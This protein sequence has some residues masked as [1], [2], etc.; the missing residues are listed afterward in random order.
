MRLRSVTYQFEYL[1]FSKDEI[2]I[3]FVKKKNPERI[4]YYLYPE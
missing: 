2:V 4:T 1:S 3:T